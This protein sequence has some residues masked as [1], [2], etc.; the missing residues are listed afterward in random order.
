MIG[1][2]Y[3][4]NRTVDIKTHVDFNIPNVVELPRYSSD[5][6]EC[7]RIGWATKCQSGTKSLQQITKIILWKLTLEILTML[8]SK[9]AYICGRCLFPTFYLM[10]SNIS[11]CF[12]LPHFTT[13][14]LNNPMRMLLLWRIGSFDAF[15]FWGKIA[16]NY[17]MHIPLCWCV[18]YTHSAKL[19]SLHFN[20]FNSRHGDL[21]DFIPGVDNISK[22]TW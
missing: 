13:Q 11:E 2:L 14:N 19:K 8:V 20:D 9:H 15:S 16:W 1:S 10:T 21:D 3:C 22:G 12:K 17:F 6:S 4:D 5:W 7:Y 18:K